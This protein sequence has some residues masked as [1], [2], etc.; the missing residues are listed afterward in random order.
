MAIQFNLA[1]NL[2][3]IGLA[4]AKPNFE[5]RFNQLQ[6][7]VI[8]R[9]NEEID[10]ITERN[11]R[12][13]EVA[14]LEKEINSLHFLIKQGQDYRSGNK[15]NLDR[16]VA[17]SPVFNSAISAFSTNDDDT[18]LT[19]DEASA[20][21]R[22]KDDIVKSLKRFFIVKLPDI[23]DGRI[24]EFLLRNIDDLENLTAVAGTVDAEGADPETNDNRNLL[25]LLKRVKNKVDTTITV[26]QN[27]IFIATGMLL[28]LQQRT[29]RAESEI[30]DISVLDALRQREEI[31][32]TKQRYGRI[33]N[34]ISLSF[35]AS[36]AFTRT[37]AADLSPKRIP[38][39]SILNIFT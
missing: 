27:S 2:M 18:N 26:T 38:A 39:G 34:A 29:L 33:L 20:I 21:N 24:I 5:L 25:D 3:T 6:N 15:N 36:S 1:Q 13:Q 14:A 31:E 16:A 17:L 30:T 4:A 19:V 32:A 9:I 8:K 7:T 23:T 22:I 28:A 10:D 37:L 12:R 35:E 11:D